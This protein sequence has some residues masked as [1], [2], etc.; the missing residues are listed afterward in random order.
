MDT[1]PV[2]WVSE[3]NTMDR[4]SES[5]DNEMWS[6]L[7][8]ELESQ[9]GIHSSSLFPSRVR[10]PWDSSL[11][12]RLKVSRNQQKTLIDPKKRHK[13]YRKPE[14]TSGVLPNAANPANF[15][16]SLGVMG[17]SMSDRDAEA[18]FDIEHMNWN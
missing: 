11:F 7:N 18:I 14:K 1:E 16:P 2:S 5:D 15:V 17:L 9:D 6:Q 12:L 13:W 10:V 8:D 4:S 3:D